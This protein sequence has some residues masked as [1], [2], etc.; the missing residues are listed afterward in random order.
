MDGRL[1]ILSVNLFNGRACPA[2]LRDVLD[3]TRP[4]V[5]AA[6]ELAPNTA[7]VLAERYRFGEIDARRDYR[8]RALV[9]S[10]PLEVVELPLPYRSGLRARLD[11]DGGDVSVASVH[12][13]NPVL[14][15]LRLRERRAQVRA[16]S[17]EL[18]GAGAL[19]L[20]G[21]LN[22][23]PIWPA[24]RRL[25]SQLADGVASWARATGRRAPPTWGFRPSGTA[26]LRI[27]HVL[28]RG[29]EVVDVAVHRVV[30]TD[31]RALV[32]DLVRGAA[33]RAG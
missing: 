13:A 29:I 18:A 1:R 30:G 17:D 20:V 23:T 9:A 24:Y 6:Q 3:R 33:R 19:V 12:L 2:S 27:D 25:T 14:P 10:V 31:H 15:R 21:D 8:G 7:R 16:L 5:V 28:V 32:A 22:S 26:R 11:L 4:D